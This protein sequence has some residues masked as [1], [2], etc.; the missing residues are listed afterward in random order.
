MRVITMLMIVGLHYLLFGGVLF[1][2]HGLNQ[3]VAWFLEAFLFVAVNCYVLI[4]GYF[5]V[6][7]KEFHIRKVASLWCQV[8][9]YTIL[10]FIMHLVLH[11]GFHWKD[12]FYVLFPI[13]Y[14]AYW[15]VTA[16]FG[17]YLLTPFLG[18]FARAMTKKQYFRFLVIMTFLF[19]VYSFFSPESDPFKVQG[20]YTVLW[21]IVLYFWG[22]YIRL[23]NLSID[24]TKAIAMYF[25]C[26][27]LT[28]LSSWP[29]HWLLRKE[30]FKVGNFGLNGFYNYNS[31]TVWLAAMALF[32]IFYKM[33]IGENWFRKIILWLG[34]LTF[35]VYLIH[36]NQYVAKELWGHWIHV[37]SAYNGSLFH[38]LGHMIVTVIGI[39]IVCILLDA[40][41]KKLFHSLSPVTGRIYEVI[42]RK[43]AKLYRIVEK[44]FLKLE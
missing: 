24:R 30:G 27:V 5:L 16:Y 9:F 3:K 26:C 1:Q 10:F 21:F 11:P 19:G 32:F 17:M 12:L 42:G 2:S 15:F 33:E 6:S 13:R 41:R 34:P 23:W 43:L 25:I 22:G 44:K 8:A 40:M 38:F 35:G 29:V 18:Y 39:F 31:P 20:G 14:N 28:F 4:S 36:M 37:S 7:K